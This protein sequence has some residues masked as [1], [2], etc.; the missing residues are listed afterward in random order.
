M[1]NKTI[2][3][4]TGALLISLAAGSIAD[5][6]PFEAEI[7]ARKAFMQV[8]KFNMGVLGGMARGKVDYDATAAE[9]AAKNMHLLTQMNNTAMYPKGSDSKSLPDETTAKPEIWS[10]AKIGEIHGQWAK[11]SATLAE[12]AGKGLPELRANIGAVGKTCKGCHDDFRT[13]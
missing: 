1:L 8:V 11:A 10:S 13:E 9:T 4:A 3:V 2:K 6:S 12:T 7:E 5:D